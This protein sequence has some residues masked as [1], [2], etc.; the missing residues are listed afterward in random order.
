MARVV[1]SNLNVMS[2][3]VSVQ[4]T[5]N[6][7][8]FPPSQKGVSAR[9]PD[10]QVLDTN[11]QNSAVNISKTVLGTTNVVLSLFPGVTP[12]FLDNLV[13]VVVSFSTTSKSG[14]ILLGTPRIALV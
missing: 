9:I 4:I 8:G 10:N 3:P 6:A 1:D 11:L 5:L 13:S 12:L 14:D 2:D 7:K